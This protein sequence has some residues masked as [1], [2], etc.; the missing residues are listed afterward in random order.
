M[1]FGGERA[2]ARRRRNYII[3]VVAGLEAGRIVLSAT[4]VDLQF[5][6]VLVVVV[7]ARRFDQPN[8]V[9][10]V[11]V[12]RRSVLDLRSGRP[13]RGGHFPTP[14]PDLRNFFGRVRLGG[15]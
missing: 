12:V 6:F 15:G 10:V 11:S 14:R 13:T 8:L 9:T 1:R 4:Q 5:V 7:F 2:L 3:I